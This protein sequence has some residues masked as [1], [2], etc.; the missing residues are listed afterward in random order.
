M[1][2]PKKNF[3]ITNSF[4]NEKNVEKNEINNY[5]ISPNPT[6]GSFSISID[7]DIDYL[8]LIDLYGKKIKVYPNHHNQFEINHLPNGFYLVSIHK[9]GLNSSFQK[10][11]KLE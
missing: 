5:T 8:D 2:L 3:E 6:N 4:E 7:S 1:V 10:L 11:M 9:N